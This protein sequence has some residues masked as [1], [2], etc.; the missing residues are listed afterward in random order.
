MRIL[1]IL[2]LSLFLTDAMGKNFYCQLNIAP[3]GKQIVAKDHLRFFTFDTTALKGKKIS[4]KDKTILI[5]NKKGLIHIGLFSG[6]KKVTVNTSFSPSRQSFQLNVSPHTELLCTSKRKTTVNSQGIPTSGKGVVVKI[7]RPLLFKY[8][9]LDGYEMTRTLIFQKGKITNSHLPPLKDTSWCL[10]RI[11]FKLNEDTLV[12]KGISIPVKRA[13]MLQNNKDF[14]VYSYSFV[15][16][17]TGKKGMETS[18]F[19]PFSLECKIK[20]EEV[21]SRELLRVITNS[22]FEITR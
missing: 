2:L 13:E 6:R 1:T 20:S 8:Y 21:F 7:K 18:R 15:D 16:F 12:P 11:E 3:V 9:T 19:V 5:W 22:S 17:A 10:F 4:F 14:K